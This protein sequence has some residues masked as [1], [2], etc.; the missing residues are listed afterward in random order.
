MSKSHYSYPPDEFDVRGP[1]GTPVGVHREPRSGWS[2][3]WPF[4]LIVVVCG[5]LAV[6]IVSFLSDDGDPA[7]PPAAE[8]SAGAGTEEPEA[9]ASADA[10]E[11]PA[12]GEASEAPADDEPSDDASDAA[13]ELPGDASAANLEASVVVYN[14]GAGSGQAAAGQGVLTS[15]GGFVD[16]AAT[17]A[18]DTLQ[19]AY[20]ETTVLYGADRADTASAVAEALGVDPAN[21]QESD[22]VTASEQAVWVVLKTPVG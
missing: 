11:P 1:E 9:S 16:V 7:T 5:G 15:D 22:D 21:V 20:E 4:L 3:V 17:D 10:E 12:D 14:D 8:Q 13:T 18:P 2:S 19:G 6:G